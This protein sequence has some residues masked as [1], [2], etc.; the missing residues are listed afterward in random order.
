M[1]FY[2]IVSCKLHLWGLLQVY[3]NNIN[4]EKN[5]NLEEYNYYPHLKIREIKDLLRLKE[6]FDSEEKRQYLFHNDTHVN[7]IISKA[8]LNRSQ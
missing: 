1:C 6:I 3:E 7:F 8:R 4:K 2:T 5:K